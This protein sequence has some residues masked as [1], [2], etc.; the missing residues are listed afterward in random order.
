[1][2]SRILS[3]DFGQKRVGISISDPQKIIASPLTTL[4]GA[5]NPKIAAKKVADQLKTLLQKNSY[6]VEKIIVGLPIHMS[7][8]ESKRSLEVREFAK[9]LEE[10]LKIPVTLFDER[11]TSVQA[12]RSLKEASLSRKRRT[13]F[14]DTVSSTILLQ[15]FL[16][17]HAI[18]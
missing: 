2:A 10:E 12:E 17:L 1:M 4:E 11:L 3:I 13:K 7:G 15:S 5:K 6:G 8:E 14:V 18:S 9:E 16:D